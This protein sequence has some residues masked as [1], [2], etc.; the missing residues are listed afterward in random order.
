MFGSCMPQGCHFTQF[1]KLLICSKTTAGEVLITAER[2]MCDL[3]DSDAERMPINTITPT[4]EKP[5]IFKALVIIRIFVFVR[6]MKLR[7][8]LCIC[9]L[10]TN[11]SSLLVT[12]SS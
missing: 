11:K 6:V 12:F 10:M 5:R 8:G 7:S 9:K 1:F 4:N 2:S 3:D